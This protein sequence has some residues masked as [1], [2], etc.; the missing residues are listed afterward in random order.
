[1]HAGSGLILCTSGMAGRRAGATSISPTEQLVSE[2]D[3][4][5]SCE[6]YEV[7]SNMVHEYVA[8]ESKDSLLLWKQR[9]QM[10]S[11]RVLNTAGIQWTGMS[12]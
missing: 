7:V 2:P 11:N 8:I 6:A 5:R 1:M 12:S 3:T 9:Q 10:D 4:G